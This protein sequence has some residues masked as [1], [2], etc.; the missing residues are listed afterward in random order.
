MKTLSLTKPTELMSI[1]NAKP[2]SF[3]RVR[4]RDGS[5]QRFATELDDNHLL[6]LVSESSLL[7]INGLPIFTANNKVLER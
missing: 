2:R 5:T 4:R 7:T 1:S 6:S 3:M